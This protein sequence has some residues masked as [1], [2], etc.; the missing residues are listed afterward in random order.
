MEHSIT[1]PVKRLG[2]ILAGLTWRAMLGGYFFLL[3][4]IVWFIKSSYLPALW[5]DP[6]FGFYSLCVT[7]YL[8][9]RFRLS[10][11]YAPVR[12]GPDE[13]PTVAVVIPG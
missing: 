8:L 1:Q 9:S 11:L 3:A 2:E 12:R 6:I 10:L 7:F 4:A 5:L 13:L